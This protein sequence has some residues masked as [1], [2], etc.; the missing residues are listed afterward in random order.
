[1][2]KKEEKQSRSIS[3]LQEKKISKVKEIEQFKVNDNI[4]KTLEEFFF[5][6]TPLKKYLTEQIKTLNMMLEDLTDRKEE[7]ET[8]YSAAIEYLKQEK[9]K[10]I[11]DYQNK[12]NSDIVERIS[13]FKK[14]ISETFS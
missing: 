10:S 3:E 13:N 4:F 11:L 6:L 7:L 1:M 8:S 2:K 5:F 9:K 12:L 14:E